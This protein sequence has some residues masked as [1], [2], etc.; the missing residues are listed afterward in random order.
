M[1]VCEP[2]R[3]T[4]DRQISWQQAKHAKLHSDLFQT[5]KRESL[6]A[7]GLQ[8]RGPQF[9]CPLRQRLCLGQM[10]REKMQAESIN[11]SSITITTTTTTILLLLLLPLLLTTTTTITTTTNASDRDSRRSSVRK[12]NLSSRQRGMKPQRK[13]AGGRESEQHPND[14]QPKPSSVQSAGG[15]AHQESDST[16]TNEHAGTDHQPSPNPRL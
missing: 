14:R 15:S 11:N 12:A 4:L 13:D 2:G 8:Q 3:Q 7:V 1:E 10:L 5:L 6:I 9:L 16:A